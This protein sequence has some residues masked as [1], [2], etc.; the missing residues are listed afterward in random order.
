[1]RQGSGWSPVEKVLYTTLVPLVA[2]IAVITVLTMLH[3]QT[4]SV[5]RAQ[6]TPVASRST[7]EDAVHAQ[8]DAIRK[9]Y[10]DCMKDMGVSL[11]G[12]HY[13]SRFSRLPNMNKIRDAIAFC[14]NLIEQQ[15]TPAPAPHRRAT[16]PV[17]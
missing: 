11:G 3:S 6:A 7:A 12:S 17:A 16:L 15:G 4:K 1:M 9:T 14:R 5:Q 13:R 2:M 8:R 10:A